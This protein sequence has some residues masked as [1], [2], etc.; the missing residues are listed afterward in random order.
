MDAILTSMSTI[1]HQQDVV[2]N[3]VNKAVD[4]QST[5]LSLVAMKMKRLPDIS[6]HIPALQCLTNLNLSKNNLF[7]GDE[8]FQVR[9]HA[10]II[11]TSIHDRTF[12]LIF[13][14]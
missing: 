13:F 2:E 5:T 14:Q 12:A 8:L 11:A 6:V 10:C 4:K 3:Y 7:N 9:H 1:I